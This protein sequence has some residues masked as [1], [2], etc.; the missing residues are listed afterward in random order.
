L[1]TRTKIVTAREAPR[2]SVLAAGYF[3]VLRV[4][5]TRQLERVRRLY[6]GRPL[7]AAILPKP[8]AVLASEARAR[9]AAA[10][11]V[12][13]Y[14]FIADDEELSAVSDVLSPAAVVRLEEPPLEVLKDAG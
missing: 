1:D 11:R 5:H 3:E 9:M 8:G 6:P 14:V 4:G 2:Q 10:L 12:V 7:V 13:D